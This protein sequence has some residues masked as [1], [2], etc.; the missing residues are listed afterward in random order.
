M[1]HKE[2]PVWK[3]THYGYGTDSRLN[4]ISSQSAATTL[5]PLNWLQ[6]TSE[7]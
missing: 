1:T 5:F 2:T 3:V 7:S 6:Q 4:D